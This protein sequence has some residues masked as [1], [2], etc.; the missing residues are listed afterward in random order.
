MKSDW[1]KAERILKNDGVVVLP[2]DTLY[3]IVGSAFSKTAIDKIYEIKKRNRD[4]PFIVLISSINDLSM[5]GINEKLEN[6]FK[7]KVS[8]L[9]SCKSQKFKYLHRGTKEIA[10]RLINSKNKNLFNLLTKIGPIVAPSANTEGEKPAET[11]KEARE[12]FKNKLGPLVDLYIN[13][14]RRKSKPSTLMRIKD[15]KIE[16]LRK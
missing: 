5:F 16:I 9:L 4:K 12:Y 10:F 2:T 3:G 13:V 14:G 6:V 8:I 7:E 15:D 1:I 11:T